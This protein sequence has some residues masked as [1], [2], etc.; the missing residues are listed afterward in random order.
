MS[1][2]D[3]KFYS[4]KGKQKELNDMDREIAAK[5]DGLQKE[6]KEKSDALATEYNAKITTERK[7]L[8]HKTANYRAELKAWCGVTEGEALDVLNVVK[9]ARD[10]SRME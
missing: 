4:L 10:A 8:D 7:D 9:M 2:F 6:Y 5:I 3:D 1:A